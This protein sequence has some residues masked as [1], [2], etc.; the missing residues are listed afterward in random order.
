VTSP[1]KIGI[2]WKPTKKLRWWRS[3]PPPTRLSGPR[4]SCSP[5]Q[6]DV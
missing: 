3:S 4:W 1:A 2:T 5:L 6:P